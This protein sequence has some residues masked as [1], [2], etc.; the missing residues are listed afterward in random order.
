MTDLTPIGTPTISSRLKLLLAAEQIAKKFDAPAPS[1]LRALRRLFVAKRFENNVRVGWKRG[2]LFEYLLA[3][4]EKERRE[5]LGDVGYY[6][7]QSFD[8]LWSLYE[9][10]VDE[11]V[12]KSAVT[13]FEK[14]AKLT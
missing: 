5:E 8:W 1:T 13:K 10:L 7:A 6:L 12:I 11:E 14:R 9:S 3:E 4:S 2:E